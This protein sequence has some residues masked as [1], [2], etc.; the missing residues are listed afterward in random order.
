MG[1][2][3]SY[4]L[5]FLSRLPTTFV[6]FLTQQMRKLYSYD[7]VFLSRLPTTFVTN[8]TQQVRKLYSYDVVFHFSPTY[9]F[10]HIPYSTDEET[11]FL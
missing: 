7:L 3:H 5:V 8:P 6:T 9:Y 11:L 1:K 10:S 4:D 2:L